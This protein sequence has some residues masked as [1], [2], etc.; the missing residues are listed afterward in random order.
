[1]QRCLLCLHDL[2]NL[3]LQIGCLTARCS[4]KQLDRHLV[5]ILPVR[6]PISVCTDRHVHYKLI[7]VA[8]YD[9]TQWMELTFIYG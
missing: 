1:M 7:K 8:A 6:S 5:N 2:T 9:L 3:T 4:N